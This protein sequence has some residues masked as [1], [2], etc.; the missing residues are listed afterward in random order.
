MMEFIL[1]NIFQT[2]H[3]D[4]TNDIIIVSWKPSTENMTSEDYKKHLSIILYEGEIRHTKYVL[5]DA[6]QMKFAIVPDLQ[7]WGAKAITESIIK[8]GNFK[9]CAIVQSPDIF[10]AVG[11]QQMMEEDEINTQKFQTQYFDDLENAKQ[12]ILK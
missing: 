12:W 5:S 7:I 10:I 3:Y 6:R 1:D 2:I 9:K 8:N 11:L 4:K